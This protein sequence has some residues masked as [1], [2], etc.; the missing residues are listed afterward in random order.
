MANHKSKYYMR[1]ALQQAETVIGNTATNPAV[2]CVVVRDGNVISAGSTSKNGRPHAEDNAIK[3]SKSKVL[4]SEIYTTLEP[5]SNYG[6]TTPCVKKIAKNKIKKVFFAMNDPDIKSFKKSKSFFNKKN[7]NV[8]SGIL[9]NKVTDFYRSYNKQKLDNLP[10]VS[11][12]IAQSKDYLT[13]NKKDKWI[14]NMYSRGRVHLIRS[15]HDCILTTC[16]TIKADNPTLNCRIKGLENNSPTR[17]IIDKDLNIPLNSKIIKTAKKYKTFLF[18]NKFKR[19]KIKYLKNFKIK[20]ISVSLNYDGGFNLSE[21][22]YQIKEL[23]FSRVLLEAGLN[24]TS[25]F[26]DQNLIDDFY[27]FISGKRLGKNGN[28][29]F[30]KCYNNYLKNKRCLKEKINLFDDSLYIYRI[31]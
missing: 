29:S 14:T 28:N 4:N 30:L 3:F 17:F 18:Y 12:K 20:L 24:M 7:I 16:K 27:I 26:L 22:L 25:K 13:N 11:A 15:F 10:F 5:C 21:I 31:K 19:K 1:L 8:H 23:G 6:K 2:G 9:L